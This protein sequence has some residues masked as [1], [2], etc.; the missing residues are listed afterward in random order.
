MKELTNGQKLQNFLLNE[1]IDPTGNSGGEDTSDEMI[2]SFLDPYGV[3]NKDD[4]DDDYDASDK[5]FTSIEAME[6]WFGRKSFN[7]FK[8]DYGLGWSVDEKVLWEV[9]EMV[10]DGKLP[11]LE[12]YKGVYDKPKAPIGKKNLGNMSKHESTK[13]LK[14]LFSDDD[15]LDHDYI[16]GSSMMGLDGLDD[17]TPDEYM[18]PVDMDDDFNDNGFNPDEMYD[19]YS[20]EFE[21][22]LDNYDDIDIADEEEEDFYNQ[23]SP[24]FR[25]DFNDDIMESKKS[26]K[27]PVN[28][29]HQLPDRMVQ[30]YTMRANAERKA[31]T[32]IEINHSL[33]YVAIDF[34]DGS[35]YF[36]QGEEASNLLDEVPDNINEED[37]ILAIAQ[38]W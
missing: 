26:K 29:A 34:R 12:K 36:F 17:S 6:E 21:D 37:Y 11:E 16:G 32:T 19:E 7:K 22:E 4:N 25:P 28:E 3:F 20:D 9:N 33:P 27:K 14:E 8:D 35:D 38:G 13:K 23:L 30:D 1:Y 18:D 24:D 15:A 5:Y 2:E 10:E 31:G